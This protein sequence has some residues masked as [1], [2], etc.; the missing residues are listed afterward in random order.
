[1][2]LMVTMLV[3]TIALGYAYV[4]LGG[5][6]GLAVYTSRITN[7]STSL[8]YGGNMTNAVFAIGLSSYMLPILIFFLLLL[9]MFIALTWL[10]KQGERATF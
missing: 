6:A 7:V 10:V 2:F 1:M 3:I 9:F 8:I 4:V 5:T